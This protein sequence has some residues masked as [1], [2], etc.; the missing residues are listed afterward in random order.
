MIKI[1]G[2]DLLEYE[3]K[4]DGFTVKGKRHEFL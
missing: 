3:F 4:S 1:E 2:R